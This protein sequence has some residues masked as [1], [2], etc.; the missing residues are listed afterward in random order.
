MSWCY[1]FS[2]ILFKWWRGS[3]AWKHLPLVHWRWSFSSLRR[4]CDS[5]TLHHCIY[6]VSK[7][8]VIPLP[9]FKFRTGGKPSKWNLCLK[10]AAG[11]GYVRGLKDHPGWAGSLSCIVLVIGLKPL[12]FSIHCSVFNTLRTRRCTTSMV[13]RQPLIR[14]AKHIQK[15]MKTRPPGAIPVLLDWLVHV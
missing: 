9:R 6:S 3:V 11:S 4:L 14:S 5:G 1:Y 8:L 10:K 12:G 2:A 7:T 13:M 15:Q